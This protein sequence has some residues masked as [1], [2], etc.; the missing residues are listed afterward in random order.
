[1]KC[2]IDAHPVVRTYG[3]SCV[4]ECD[5]HTRAASKLYDVLSALHQQADTLPVAIQSL[6]EQKQQNQQRVESGHKRQRS[7][8]HHTRASI[9]QSRTT[10]GVVPPFAELT[11][12]CRAMLVRCSELAE[13]ERRCESELSAIQ[14]HIA[15]LQRALGLSF[16]PKPS[17]P[18]Q[19][20]H[21]PL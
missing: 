18:I 4:S 6:S 11:Y 8:H 12:L 3:T 21:P 19:R 13:M 7:I 16:V 9:L 17:Q 1:M 2:R 10:Y 20:T 5:E 14:Q 15:P